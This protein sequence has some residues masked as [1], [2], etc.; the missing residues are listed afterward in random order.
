MSKITFKS[1]TVRIT[2]AVIACL[3]T[4]AVTAKAQ[5]SG[6]FSVHAV[7]PDNQ[8][9]RRQTYFDLRMKPGDTQTIQFTINN[10]RAEE[11]V[12]R[13]QLNAASTG[14]NGLIVYTEPSVRDD[15][16]KVSITDVAR[17]SADTVTVPA[18]G[19][20][21][22][23]IDIHMPD[24]EL[25][26]VILGGI[27]VS[28]DSGETTQAAGGVALENT[29]TYVIGLKLT[30]NDNEIAPDFD[31]TAIKPA[32]VNHK[33]AVVA[34]LHNK[35][36]RIVKS[37]AVAAQ[38][39]RLGSNT[40][41]YGL[42]IENAEMAP[43]SKGDFVINWGNKTLQ[44]GTYRLKMTAKYEEKTWEWDENFTIAGEVADI[45][46]G[47]VG[48]EKNYTLFYLISALILLLIAWF[49]AYWLG[50]R[51]KTNEG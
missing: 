30:E 31:L 21:A 8:V 13:V 50:K 51:R 45:N 44:T 41:L 18:F 1:L 38:V 32:L 19:A 48:I 29:I 11:L 22:V 4:P 49:T 2:A 6:D 26:G 39:Y 35:A 27:A 28:A 20:K 40:V 17:L 24:E 36:P 46:N 33:T 15:S 10:S 14:R 12:A 23:T 37:M 47:A 7:I 43:L 25:D 34:T 5:T 3:L 9:D 42:D 16:L